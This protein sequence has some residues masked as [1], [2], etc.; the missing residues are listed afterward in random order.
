VGTATV[1]IPPPAAR[2]APPDLYAPVRQQVTGRIITQLAAAG[3]HDLN[4]IPMPELRKIVLAY[5]EEV[6][7]A[8]RLWSD[9]AFRDR[10]ALEILAGM[11]R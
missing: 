9:A 2:P 10:L 4:R 1:R 11:K 3:V 5:V 7:E 8:E 6:C